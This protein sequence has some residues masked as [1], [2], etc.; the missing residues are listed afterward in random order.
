MRVG[1]FGWYGRNNCGDEAFKDAFNILL[2]KLS[3]DYRCD[4]PD[5]DVLILGGGDVVKSY[6]LD[7]IG[8]REFFLLGAGLGYESELD[9]LAGKRIKRAVFRN[10]RDAALAF[11]KGIDAVWCPDLAFAIPAPSKMKNLGRKRAVVILND[12]INPS[13]DKRDKASEIAYAEYLKWEL[14]DS[15][16]YL[17]EWYDITFMPFSAERRHMDVK[18]CHD[19]VSRMTRPGETIVMPAPL[20]PSDALQHISNADLVITMKFHGV[21]FA[22]L[23]S[24]PFVNIGLSRKTQ[25]FCKE[26]GLG[27]LSV[28]SYGFSQ[29]TFLSAVKAAEEI[30][31]EFLSGVTTYNRE[32]LLRVF[33]RIEEEICNL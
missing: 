20:I 16:S 13:F 30:D 33:P 12:V 5:C 17:S 4:M 2:P 15:L 19:V 26:S 23:S 9:L 18:C 22:T 29:E 6:Y 10:R 3:K 11:A 8:D 31:P 28:P 27:D 24:T 25:Q 21:I 14:A 32:M 1:I 7:V